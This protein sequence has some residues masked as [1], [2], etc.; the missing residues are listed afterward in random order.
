MSAAR[1]SLRDPGVFQGIRGQ[2]R[3]CLCLVRVMTSRREAVP[4]DE[5][6]GPRDVVDHRVH[7]LPSVGN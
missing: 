7:M 5:C 2:D 1:M 6:V 4:L 3:L